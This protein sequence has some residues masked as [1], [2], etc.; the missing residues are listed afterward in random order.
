M[1]VDPDRELVE[2]VRAGER[3]T[4]PFD[5]FG[6]DVGQREWSMWVR[7]GELSATGSKRAVQ[8]DAATDPMRF[9]LL[10]EGGAIKPG[11]FR[12]DGDK[13]VIAVVDHWVK[14][15]KLAKGEDH[16]AR[17]KGFKSTKDNGVAVYILRRASGFF[18]QD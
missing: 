11:I 17:P 5:L 13:L 2:R 4:D 3:T 14:Q 6:W 10:D 18:A 1:K 15:R 7:R 12:F 16:P 8:V 9:D